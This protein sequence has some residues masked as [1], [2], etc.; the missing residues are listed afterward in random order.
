MLLKGT[1]LIV[2]IFG[3][4]LIGSRGTATAAPPMWGKLAAWPVC[5]R[6][7][8][9]LA[10]RL[11]PRLQHGFRRQDNLS[12]WQG[13]RPILVNTWYPAE[14]SDDL[15]PM[16]HSDYLK[17]QTE[18]PRLARFA[19]KMADFEHDIVSTEVMSKPAA[20]LNDDECRLLD[21]HWAAPSACL[22]RRCAPRRAIS[23]GYL[24]LR[25]SVF[26]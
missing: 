8:V 15:L 16:P 20:Q 14:R 9:T 12:L 7:Q 19:A 18:D 11:Y 25:R 3:S 10:T 24:S 23:P 22:R 26:I 6:F 13:A 21:R 2:C 5:R 4:L 17:I 1:T